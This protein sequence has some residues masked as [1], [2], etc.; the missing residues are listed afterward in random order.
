MFKV[1]DDVIYFG[2]F[3]AK[4]IAR[5]EDDI[6]LA[7]TINNGRAHKIQLYTDEL[8]HDTKLRRYL[9][10]EELEKVQNR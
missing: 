6:F 5:L 7:V 2:Q 3:K 10:E 8:E 9:S 1:G 4:L